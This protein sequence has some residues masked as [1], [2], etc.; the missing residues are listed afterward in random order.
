VED[1]GLVINDADGNL[2]ARADTRV[3]LV[4][5]YASL[6]H[7]RERIEGGLPLACRSAGES[8]FITSGP[9]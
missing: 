5:G 8:Y 7:V 4:G 2:V 9:A 1:T 3:T 6:D